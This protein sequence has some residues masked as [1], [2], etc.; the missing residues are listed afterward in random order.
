MEY[1]KVFFQPERVS[2]SLST[3]LLNLLESVLIV[4]V[5]LIF[6]MGL[7]SGIILSLV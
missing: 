1:E 7:K 3:F 6:F 2:D 5:V 4:V